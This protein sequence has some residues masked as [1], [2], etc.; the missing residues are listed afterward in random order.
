MKNESIAVAPLSSIWWIGILGAALAITI[1]ITL[2]KQVDQTWEQRLRIILGILMLARMVWH[3]WMFQG[4]GLWFVSDTLPM[5]LC[6]I[7][8]I[9]GALF[10]IRPHQ[11]G[12]EILVLLGLPGAIQALITPEITFGP[13]VPLFFEYYISHSG[14]ILAGLYLFIVNG[15]RL[16][17]KSWL[18]S[19]IVGQGLMVSIAFLNYLIDANYMYLCEKPLVS[20]PLIFGDWPWYVLGF[21]IVGILHILLFYII[22]FYLGRRVTFRP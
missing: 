7:T 4:L 17:P 18:I 12:F 22:F 6:G 20:H 16:R 5:H 15:M 14:V 19:V 2:A 11:L 13:K 10:L 21:E 3:D 1:I 9:L 8:S